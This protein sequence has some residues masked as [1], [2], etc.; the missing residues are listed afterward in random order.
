MK[1]DT[2]VIT[3]TDMMCAHCEAS[4]EKALSALGVK[5]KA[6]R[7]A[8]SVTVSYDAKKVSVEEMKAAIREAGFTAE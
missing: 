4:V 2:A 7:T 5:A 6:D 8:K 1:K 3:V